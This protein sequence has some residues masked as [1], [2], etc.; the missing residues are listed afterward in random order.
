M[1]SSLSPFFVSFTSPQ[2]LVTL[3]N[4]VPVTQQKKAFQD[5][6]EF[7][8]FQLSIGKSNDRQERRMGNTEK[9][10]FDD[11]IIGQI[12]DSLIRAMLKEEEDTYEKIFDRAMKDEIANVADMFQER[13]DKMNIM[14]AMMKENIAK[15]PSKADGLRRGVENLTKI[16]KNL[17]QQK[18]CDRIVKDGTFISHLNPSTVYSVERC[19]ISMEI[20]ILEIY[21]K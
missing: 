18:M 9:D 4:V 5:F 10:D 20:S 15:M 7:T 11:E 12:S 21:A 19:T 14:I 8:T 3:S 6:F 1:N 16:R 17:K 13:I 2:T